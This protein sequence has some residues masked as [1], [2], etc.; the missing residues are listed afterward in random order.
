MGCWMVGRLLLGELQSSQGWPTQYTNYQL[1]MME[2][3]FLTL[4]Y[5]WSAVLV[6]H[7]EMLILLYL[8]SPAKLYH[9]C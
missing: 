5:N 9:E 4:Q 8:F 7:L 1:R 3:P 6:T 2:L